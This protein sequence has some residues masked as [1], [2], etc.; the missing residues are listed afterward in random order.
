MR[1]L[2]TAA[3]RHDSTLGI[4]EAIANGL[5]RRGI[6]ADMLP[7][8]Q[9]HGLAGYDA[10][11]IGSAV[12]VG[13]WMRPAIAWISA[14]SA[15]L[16]AMPVWLFSSGPLGPPDDPVPATAPA[17]VAEM[18]ALTGAREHR[19]FAGRL[20]RAQLRIAERA[21]VKATRANYG[22]D[23]DWEAIDAFANEIAAALAGAVVRS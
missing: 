14:N 11:V 20:D 19:V 9:V 7:V 10:A 21:M 18:M 17:D 4:A 16:A 1:V 6:E 15:R 5:V 23:R 12:Y 13:R 3:S 22:D 8:D 2:V